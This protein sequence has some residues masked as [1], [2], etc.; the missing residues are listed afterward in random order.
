MH[1]KPI[2]DD[3]GNRIFDAVYREDGTV[4]I[5]V[6]H[7]KQKLCIDLITVLKQVEQGKR[8]AEEAE[9]KAHTK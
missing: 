1:S 3:E 2:R 7:A 5:E 4:A 9:R 8:Q 6:K